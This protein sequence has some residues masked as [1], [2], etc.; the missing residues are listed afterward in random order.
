MVNALPS[1]G[2]GGLG[3]LMKHPG[4]PGD[5]RAHASSLTTESGKAIDQKAI[6]DH[7]FNPATDN[8]DGIAAPELQAAPDPVRKS[9][10]D[11]SSKLAWAA[12]PLNYWAHQIEAFNTEVDKISTSL[13]T[14]AGKDGHYGATGDS[15]KPPTDDQVSTAKAT[16]VSGAD[17]KWYA[18]YNSFI[19][20]G[21]TAVAGMFKDGPT[22]ANVK[23]ANS[24]G[25]I[26]T[27]PGVFTVY[28]AEWHQQE[29][30]A[31]AKQA[32]ALARK[33]NT[34]G[35]H[36]S[37]ADLVQLNE[38]LKNQTDPAFASTFLNEVGPKGLLQLTIN[39]A[40]FQADL[41]HDGSGRLAPDKDLAALMA[42]VQSGLGAVL[43]VGTRNPG[44]KNQV[45]PEWLGN[46][47]RAG[48]DKM[49][50]TVAGGPSYGHEG[51]DLYGYQALGVLLGTN[52]PEAKFGSVFLSTA[53]DD[54]IAFEREHGGSEVW[55]ISTSKGAAGEGYR[56]NWIDG[57]AQDTQAGFDPVS[58]LMKALRYDDPSVSKE[59]FTHQWETDEHNAG[60][61]NGGHLSLV[62]YLLTERDWQQDLMHSND[63]IKW[64]Q[65][66]QSYESNGLNLL[67]EALD[68]A[69]TRSIQDADSADLAQSVVYELG[70]NHKSTDHVVPLVIKD[71]VAHIV[72][73]N[74]NGVYST[75]NDL[76]ANA[77]D[78][79][80]DPW[81]PGI[82]ND[83]PRFSKHELLNVLTDLGKDSQAYNTVQ[84]SAVTYAAIGYNYYLD[85][86]H[87]DGADVVSKGLGTVTGFIDHGYN[88]AKHDQYSEDDAHYNEKIDN[89]KK[90]VDFV[91]GKAIGKIPVGGDIVSTA[92]GAIADSVTDDLHHDS[93]NLA[94]WDA[95]ENQLKGQQLAESTY[96]A[97]AYNNTDVNDLPPALTDGHGNRITFGSQKWT[98]NNLDQDWNN[99][100]LSHGGNAA[101]YGNAGTAYQGAYDS[102]DDILK[103]YDK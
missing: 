59:W 86:H 24:V 92:Y 91:V 56:L 12:V 81:T 93:T 57:Y 44:Q 76:P 87:G 64:R 99:Y 8:W 13:T 85:G 30:Q 40:D 11:L 48:R 53:G 14:A 71:S 39:I 62:K 36:P 20:S 22:D 10:H 78:G 18:A 101:H 69:T 17:T 100:L 77:A 42:S 75:V 32:A 26:P 73:Y 31:K 96:S 89:T 63:D 55:N 50:S 51:I 65:D 102:V 94:N 66:H 95:G 45:S 68:R 7:A 74:M 88:E 27:T 79:D 54:M 9:A 83:V 23:L 37:K 41:G 1:D 5:I 98:E 35:Y 38:L 52:N 21:A 103:E 25:A 28:Q 90:V 72:A 82:Q 43:A 84:H 16:A 61:N 49:E 3:P 34:P 70:H 47:M 60:P 4:R 80:Q 46:L 6:T 67:G 2:G 33:I 19:V 15:G 58:G 29:M 97:A